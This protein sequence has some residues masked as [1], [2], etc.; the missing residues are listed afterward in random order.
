MEDTSGRASLTITNTTTEK[1]KK[2]LSK[3]FFA[4]STNRTIS[5]TTVSAEVRIQFAYHHT[6]HIPHQKQQQFRTKAQSIKMGNSLCCGIE[7]DGS[8]QARSE[9]N[10]FG[11]KAKSLM[12]GKLGSQHRILNRNESAE[13]VWF[14]AMDKFPSGEMPYPPTLSMRQLPIELDWQKTDSVRL[15]LNSS[16]SQSI[17]S[18]LGE[19]GPAPKELRASV[20][21]VSNDLSAETSGTQGQGYPGEL[22]EEELETCLKFR[23]ELKKRDPAFKEMV[24]AMHP[25]ENEAFALCRF[26]R[27][28]DFVYEEV[29]TM[30]EE[31]IGDWHEVKEKDPNF[32]KD[33]ATTI[34]EFNGCPLPVFLTQMPVLHMGIGKNGAIITYFRAGHVNVPGVECIVGDLTNALPFTW[35]RLYHGAREA[36]KREIARSDTTNTTV[37]AEKILIVDLKGDSVLFTTQ[38]LPFL[39]L[40]PSAGNCFPENINRTYLLNAPFSF[41]IIWAA[42]KRILEERTLNKI[43]FFTTIAKAK[44]D[45]FQHIDSDQLCSNYGGTGMSFDELIAQRQ[46][47]YAHKEGVVRY[48]VELMYMTGRSLEFAFDLASIEKVDSIVVYSRSKNKCEMSVVDSK[49]MSVVENKTVSKRQATS[50]NPGADVSE[51]ASTHNNYAVEIATSE[52]FASDSKGTFSVKAKGGTRGDY[53]LVA[54]SIAEN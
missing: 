13:T 19:S 34:P 21:K 5:Q 32:F 17:A 53:F 24:M 23:E 14:D 46:R 26:L 45:F 50:I 52:D 54:I 29:F 15:L 41:S 30:M 28:R 38:G 22:T 42:A 47:E 3:S 1:S 10:G 31:Q 51:K 35:N 36:M 8:E 44:R 12:T 7:V 39:R 33:F 37:L 11:A 2:D 18:G 27:A 16:R 4:P 43:G 48:V 6:Y 49:G 9:E 25:H 20:I 40:S